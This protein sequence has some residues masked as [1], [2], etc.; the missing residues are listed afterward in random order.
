MR[1]IRGLLG[2]GCCTKVGGISSGEGVENYSLNVRFS[3]SSLKVA[4]MSEIVIS[5]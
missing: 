2:V 3:V 5:W 4:A 1:I